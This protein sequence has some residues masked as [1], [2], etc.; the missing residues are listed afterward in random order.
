M[1][2]ST[3]LGKGRTALV[4]GASRGIGTLIAR[5]VASQ[6]GHVV[7]TGRSAADLRSVTA[8]LARSGLHVS[9][10]PA[11]L[12][13]PGA[14]QT[15][16]QAVERKH[17]GVDL[18]VNNAGGDPLREFHTMTVEENLRILQLNLIA[19]VALS[20]AVLPGMLTRGRGH[21]V[22]ISAMAG[23]V[24]F[25]YTEVYAAA[26]DGLI[27]FTR[28]LRNDYHAR[29]VSASV[30][31]LGAI[32]GTGQ[33]Q[34]MLDD[35]GM[36]TSPYMTRAE[37]VA[38]AVVKAVLNDRIELVVMPGPARLLRAILDYYPR[39][40]PAMNKAAGASTT[41]QRIIQMREVQTDIGATPGAGTS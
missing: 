23:R 22:N 10:V 30:L 20:H 26:K 11:D 9:C 31:I 3:V 32:R 41:M 21:I 2:T 13:Q 6:G 17:G 38:Q 39:L 37:T 28:V 36:K 12:T 27:G 25:P 24:S 34:R 18:L 8:E 14:A 35:A 19:P 5:Q 1:S 4:T 29:G 7:L 40:G 16:V 33:G 15:I